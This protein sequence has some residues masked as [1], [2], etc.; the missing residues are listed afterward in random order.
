M[1]EIQVVFQNDDFVVVNKPQN[2]NFHS[3]NLP[4]LVVFVQQML[5]NH[6]IFPVHRLDKM[7][8]GLILFAKHKA[9]A[10]ALNELFAKQ[11]V[12]RFYIALGQGKPKKKQGWV[13]G[14][15]LPARRGSWKLST[16]TENPAI[17][18]FVSESV[19]PGL[20]L[21]LLKLHTG[22]THQIRVALK[23]LSTPVLGDQRYQ[24]AALAQAQ[25]RGYLHAYGLRFQW[26]GQW[27]EW[28]LSPTT[29][30][31]F[32]T[33]NVQTILQTWQTPWTLFNANEKTY[34][35]NNGAAFLGE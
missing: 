6:A 26:Q 3:E 31:Q 34:E 24:E 10:V 2:M 1:V 21:F 25:D 15:M 18:Q 9:A 5:P 4:G 17:T 27:V 32:L 28:V 14:D 12:Q 20:R 7:T 35:P 19:A 33:D 29:G 11:Q 16:T 23:S 8:S 30:A 13:K 22:K